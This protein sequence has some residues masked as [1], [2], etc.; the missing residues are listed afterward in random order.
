MAPNYGDRPINQMTTITTHAG[1]VTVTDPGIRAGLL[2]D[3]DIRERVVRGESVPCQAD[4]AWWP[5]RLPAANVPAPSLSRPCAVPEAGTA[6]AR[7]A[8]R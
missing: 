2:S 7:P 1:T 3:D 6:P 8:G 5:S 4:A